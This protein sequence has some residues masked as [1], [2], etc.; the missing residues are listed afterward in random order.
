M[1]VTVMMRTAKGMV[2]RAAKRTG[3][4]GEPRVSDE[5][6]NY[7]A[8]ARGSSPDALHAA[9]GL[10]AALNP[11]HSDHACALALS[12]LGAVMG[13]MRRGGAACDAVILPLGRTGYFWAECGRTLTDKG[14]IAGLLAIPVG[15]GPAHS[16]DMAAVGDFA[17]DEKGRIRLYTD[18]MEWLRRYLKAVRAEAART[19]FDLAA[20]HTQPPEYF[21]TLIL[22][23]KAFPWRATEPAHPVWRGAKEIAKEIVCMD[24][25]ELGAFVEKELKARPK[26]ETPGLRFPQPTERTAA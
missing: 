11:L 7:R 13:R 14:L 23:A 8:L 9:F 15:G 12:R 20:E 16:A 18:G 26:V 10:S 22:D 6:W 25:A 17:P 21:G 19:G 4:G 1:R 3:T 2:A 24:S 5:Y